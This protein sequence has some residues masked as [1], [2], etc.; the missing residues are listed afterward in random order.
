MNNLIGTI[1]KGSA[2]GDDATFEV[3]NVCKDGSDVF[4]IAECVEFGTPNQK[5]NINDINKL[6]RA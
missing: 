3:I 2:A 5:I 1:L 6:V 4:V